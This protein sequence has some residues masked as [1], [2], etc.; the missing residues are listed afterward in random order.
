MKVGTVYFKKLSELG[1]GTIFSFFGDSL[2][3]T[4]QIK[5]KKQKQQDHGTQCHLDP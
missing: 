3:T 5:N 1:N 2:A 4:P